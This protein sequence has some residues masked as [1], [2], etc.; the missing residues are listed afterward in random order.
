MANI[1]NENVS[2]DRFEV[3]RI[4]YIRPKLNI[5]N[6]LEIS[7]KFNITIFNPK[8]ENTVDGKIDA[9]VFSLN[10]KFYVFVIFGERLRYLGNQAIDRL[11]SDIFKILTNRSASK[12]I[13]GIIDS[14]EKK[15]H[16]E[17]KDCKL[18]HSFEEKKICDFV[19]YD[20]ENCDFVNYELIYNIEAN[21]INFNEEEN[22][23]LKEVEIND[24]TSGN[25]VIDDAKVA[26][27]LAKQ[28]KRENEDHLLAVHLQ[29]QDDHTGQTTITN[30]TFDSDAKLARDLYNLDLA[31]YNDKTKKE[32]VI[33]VVCNLIQ[34]I[35]I[36]ITII[37]FTYSF[38]T[39]F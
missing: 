34:Y 4:W 18:I 3:Y 20:S 9:C 33:F 2:L 17:C 19:N 30:D 35:Q 26:E 11:T 23:E 28:F 14:F 7:H 5:T 21:E 32:F 31:Q 25:Q 36:Q 27:Q 10:G 8:T 12:T 16:F 1:S 37:F 38:E 6:N 29:T 22:V 13:D 24:I 39:I 15:E